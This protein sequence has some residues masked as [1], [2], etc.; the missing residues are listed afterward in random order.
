MSA[1]PTP[2]GERGVPRGSRYALAL[3]LL[4]YTVNHVDRQ[5]MYILV[6]PVRTEFALDDWQ[7]GWIAGGGFA[8]F[9]A[10]MGIPIGRIADRIN[11]RNLISLALA[12]WSLFTA[13]SGLAR[14]FW[15]LMA[16]RSLDC[17]AAGVGVVVPASA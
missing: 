17:L 6:E 5:L 1:A 4:I 7:M 15:Q 11:R 10:F 13:A 14:G 12:V 3:L 8:L 2:S 9:Y 16:A